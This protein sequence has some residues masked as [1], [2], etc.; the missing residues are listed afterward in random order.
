MPLGEKVASRNEE[1]QVHSGFLLR[2]R[3]RYVQ[4]LDQFLD[5][6]CLLFDLVD[7]E[8]ELRND[9]G[10]VADAVTQCSPYFLLMQV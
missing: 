3:R 6:F 10:L 2:I 9:P 5:A 4:V 8:H 1:W 7:V